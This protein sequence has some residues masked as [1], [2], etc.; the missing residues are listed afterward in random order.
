MS[1]GEGHEIET[2]LLDGQ[3]DAEPLQ[4]DEGYQAQA[5]HGRVRLGHPTP[6]QRL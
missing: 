5:E 6:G 3:G 4:P 2:R 1:R